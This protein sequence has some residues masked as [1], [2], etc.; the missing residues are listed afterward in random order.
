MEDSD[1]DW[2][3]VTKDKNHTHWTKRKDRYYPANV[4]HQKLPAG[5]YET[6]VDGDGNVFAREIV[7]PSDSLLVMPGMPT[8]YIVGQIKD[9][10]DRKELFAQVG[11]LFKRGIL[12]YGPAGCGKTSLIRLLC[13]EIINRNGV[14]FSVSGKIESTQQLLLNLR[15]IEPDRAIMTIF[16]DIEKM[17]EDK[18]QESDV[19]S[20][21]DGEKQIENIVHI[22]T[23]NKP[24]QLEDRLVKRP[25]RFDLIVGLNPP[26]AEAREM[27]L[28]HLLKGTTPDEQIKKMVAD[29]DGM[30]LAH[31]RELVV[32]I[33]C[34]NLDY[35]VTLKRLKGNI[36]EVI[37]MPKVGQK[38]TVGFT[39]G[40]TPEDK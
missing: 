24:D 34:L 13:D 7:F 22:A 40:F 37:R 21:L 38:S 25:G 35:T 26:I 30:G 33:L 10:W 17:M 23:T 5:I 18:E 39:L 15:E 27:Y 12:L 32:S 1:R 6:R 8:D 19:L 20:F 11:F 29:T 4:T 36:K 14:V 9:F 16:E 28:R 3:Y 31:L 2:E